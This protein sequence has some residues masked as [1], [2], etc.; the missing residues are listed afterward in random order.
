MSFKDSL[1]YLTYLPAATKLGRGNV[2][3]G[4]CDSVHGGGG[5]GVSASVHAGMLPWTRDLP[6]PGRPP[7]PDTPLDQADPP[8]PGRPPPTR[9]TPSPVPGRPPLETDARIWS[10]SGRY[11]SYWNAFLL[12]CDITMYYSIIFAVFEII[13]LNMPVFLLISIKIRTTN[14]Y[15]SLLLCLQIQHLRN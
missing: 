9:Q 3:T 1:E 13:F 2:F 10:M 5:G 14:Q 11:A 8:G 7:R 15:C 12:L 6:R 4:V